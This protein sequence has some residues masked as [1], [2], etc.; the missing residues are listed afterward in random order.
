MNSNEYF[1]G[2][3]ACL[4][5]IKELKHEVIRNFD[6]T[7]RDLMNEARKQKQLVTLTSDNKKGH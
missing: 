3:I 2:W 5:V 7:I 1:F 4:H 6:A